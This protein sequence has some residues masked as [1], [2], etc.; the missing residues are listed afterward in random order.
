[1]VTVC[2]FHRRADI[3]KKIKSLGE[4]DCFLFDKPSNGNPI[5]VLHYKIRP[6]VIH[7]AGIHESRDVWMI[8][9]GQYFALRAEATDDIIIGGT[10]VQY[11]DSYLLLKISIRARRQIDCSHPASANLPNND[12][13][14]DSSPNFRKVF[15][16]N[17]NR[18]TLGAFF[19]WI[20]FVRLRD[21]RFDLMQKVDIINTRA[22]NHCAPG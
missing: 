2:R 19:A 22:A 7:C 5:D 21:E 4:V 14:A 13:S 18:Q 8:E 9:A 11:F 17:R 6:A 10:T 15:R 12:V 3:E 1:M 16:R 20:R